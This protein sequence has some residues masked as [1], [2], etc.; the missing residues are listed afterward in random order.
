MN[1]NATALVLSQKSKHLVYLCLSKMCT[2]FLQFRCYN[3]LHRLPTI[4][5]ESLVSLCITHLQGMLHQNFPLKH[6]V[7]IIVYLKKE[8]ILNQD[9]PLSLRAL[10]ILIELA[11]KTQWSDRKCAGCTNSLKMAHSENSMHHFEGI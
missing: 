2:L 10:S 6:P 4:Q 1:R 11:C 9:E 3:I 5:N 7:Q 8:K